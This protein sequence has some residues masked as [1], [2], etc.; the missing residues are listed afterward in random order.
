MARD[1]EKRLRRIPGAH[2]SHR[3]AT[4][5]DET[6]PPGEL[7]VESRN[8]GPVGVRMASTRNALLLSFWLLATAICSAYVAVTTGPSPRVLVSDDLQRFRDRPLRSWGLPRRVPSGRVPETA[9]AK[10][11]P[12]SSEQIPIKSFVQP[13][14]RMLEVQASPPLTETI[15]SFAEPKVRTPDVLLPERK[16]T[17]SPAK[18]A[19]DLGTLVQGGSVTRR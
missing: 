18:P 16:V 11:P 13:K 3:T 8:G 9:I 2:H 4:A 5:L 15:K 19:T 12:S 6:E 14:R 7:H 1:R 10:A 17:H